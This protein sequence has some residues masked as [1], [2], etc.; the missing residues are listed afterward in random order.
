[1]CLKIPIHNEWT[2]LENLPKNQN[3][4]CTINEKVTSLFSKKNLVFIATVM[5][6][7]APQVTPVW[8]DLEDNRIMVNTAKG[9]V[10]HK[11]I[12]RD[13]RVAISVVSRA[14]PLDMVSIRGIV[15]KIIPD[16]EYQH[17]DR[18]TRQYMDGRDTYPFKRDGEKRITLKIRPES[19]FVMPELHPTK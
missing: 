16:Y 19:I 6:D 12:L 1:M 7:G 3:Q 17:A 4:E 9:R 14:N 10:K 13:P 2:T 15:E 18:L 8:A 11:N 5:S